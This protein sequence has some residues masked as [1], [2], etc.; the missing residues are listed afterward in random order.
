VDLRKVYGQLVEAE[1]A[2]TESEDFRKT[3]REGY[4]AFV[5]AHGPLNESKG[6]SILESAKDP[7][8]PILAALERQTPAGTYEPA[9]ILSKPTMRTKRRPENPSIRDAFVML[10]NESMDVDLAR[11]AELAGTTE[12][13]VAAELLGAGAIFRTP[14]GNY[15]VRDVYLSG[16]VRRKLREAIEAH[17]NG[18]D[19][20]ANIEELKKVIPPDVPYFAIEAKLG[21]SW[22]STGHYQQFIAE[23]LGVTGNEVNEIEIRPMP[24]GWKVSLPEWM[25]NKPEAR[26]LW[27]VPFY[28]FSNL[29]RAA[30]NN[31]SVTIRYKDENGNLVVDEP[32]SKTAN[33]KAGRIRE[34]FGQWAW[35][36]TARRVQLERDYNEVMNSAADPQFD[37]SFLTFDGMALQRG[38]SEFGLRQHQSDAIWRG[39]A[40][41][42]GIYGH[43]VGTGKTYT[44]GGIAVESRRYGLA[45]KPLLLAHNA[46]SASVAAEIRE[47]YPAA[48][49]LYVDNLS[50][51]TV[52]TTLRQ[53]TNDDWDAVV[54][55]HS[56]IDNF[57][58]S[59]ATL[60]GLVEAEIAAFEEE[61]LAAAAEDGTDLTLAMMDDEDAMKKVRSA[62]AKELVKARN[63]IKKRVRDMALRASKEDAV[64]FEDMGIDMILVDEAHEFKK[65][66]LATRMKLKGLNAGTSNRSI[67]LRFLTDYVRGMNGGRGVH[68]FTGTPI[69]NTLNEIYNQM[70]YVMDDE[71]A[72]DGVQAWDSWFNTFADAATDVELTPTGEYEPVTRLSS[73]VNVAELR[74]MVGQYMHIVFADEMP[75][76]KPRPTSD[77]RTMFDKNLTEAE[78][79]ELLNSRSERPVGRPYKKVVNDTAEMSPVQRAVLERLIGYSRDFKNASKKDRRAIMLSGDPRSPLLVE[80]A[81]A[82]AGFDARLYDMS[83]PDDPNSKVNRAV[84]N[85]LTHY[86]E[87]PAATQVIFME[88][89]FNDYSTRTRT[90][91][92]GAKTTQRVPKFN[93]AKDI[94]SKL[95]AGGIPREQIAIVTGETSKDKR[96]E[97]AD[98]MNRSEIRVVVGSSATLGVGVNMQVNLRAM[99]HL[100]A[101]WMPGLLEQRNGRGHRQ[102]NKWNTVLEYRYL[103][104]GL[105]GRRWQVLAI[106]QKF[107]TAFLKADSSVRIIEGDAVSLDESEGM[108]DLAESLS[109]AAG[110]PRILVRE[111]LKGD[112]RK[113]EMRERMHSQ[114]VEDALD[115]TA[116]QRR[117]AFNS[118]EAARAM[119]EDAA[120]YEKEREKPFAMVIG[121][122]T[123]DKRDAAQE[124]LDELRSTLPT[125]PN[126][127]TAIGNV[128]GFRMRARFTFGGIEVSLDRGTTF[129]QHK[130]GRDETHGQVNIINAGL[131][132]ASIEAQLRGL[133]RRAGLEAE[134]ADEAEQS[135]VKFERAAETP[136]GQAAALTKKRDLLKQLETD[137]AKFPAAAPAWLRNGAPMGTDTFLKDRDKGTVQ[138]HRWGTDNWW[139]LVDDGETVKA[140]PYTDL[141]DEN[142]LPVFDERP[143]E[144]PPMAQTGQPAGQG[145]PASQPS[146]P[147]STPRGIKVGD[148]VE[149]APTSQAIDASGTWT[150]VS[151]VPPTDAGERDRDARWDVVIKE[152]NGHQEVVSASVLRPLA[153]FSRVPTE[154]GSTL[155]IGVRELAHS[156]GMD[157][158]RMVRM[159]LVR[160]VQSPTSLPE[161]IKSSYH[162]ESLGYVRGVWDGKTSYLVADNIAAGDWTGV[163]LHESGTH[164]SLATMIGGEFRALA[165]DFLELVKAGDKTAKAIQNHIVK[166]VRGNEM[167]PDH[168]DE[169]RIAYAVEFAANQKPGTFTGRFKLWLTRVLAALRAWFYRSPLY[170]RLEAKGFRMKLSA[171][172]MAALARQ[173]VR[174]RTA[175]AAVESGLKNSFRVPEV[176]DDQGRMNE[177]GRIP[178]S[179]ERWKSEVS[180]MAYPGGKTRGALV[181]MSPEDFLFLAAD[182]KGDASERAEKYGA[183][184]AEKFNSDWLPY[185]E[186]RK[187]GKVLDHEGRAR[188]EMAMKSGI[189]EIPVILTFDKRNL[190]SSTDDLPGRLEQQKGD[191]KVSTP[192]AIL[193]THDAEYPHK[194]ENRF[195]RSL[196][197]AI[198]DEIAFTFVRDKK[199][200]PLKNLMTQ[201]HKAWKN[202]E[203]KPVFDRGQDFLTDTTKYAMQAESLAPDMLVRLESLKDVFKTGAGQKDTEAIA[204]ALFAGT[205]DGGANPEDGVVWSDADLSANFGLNARQIG[206]YHQARKAIDASL[207]TA[208]IT[209]LVRLGRQDK[210]MLDPDMSLEDVAEV[211]RQGLQDRIDAAKVDL[212]QKE[213]DFAVLKPQRTA[214][215]IQAK[216]DLKADISDVKATI[217]TLKASLDRVNETERRANS[218]KEHGYFPLMRFGEHR[219]TIT[220]TDAKGEQNV[221]FVGHYETQREALRNE[222]NLLED[223]EHQGLNVQAERRVMP[224]LGHELYRGI[225]PETVSLFA[226]QTGLDQDP[227]LQEY[228]K[229]AI[230]G[231][232]AMKRLIHRK[233]MPGF[234]TDIKRAL[235]AFITS[236]AR[237]ASANLHMGPMLAAVEKIKAGDVKDDAIELYRYLTE[238]KEEAAAFRSFLFFW[239]IGASPASALVN[240]T[241]PVM[242]T[243]PYLAQHGVK[244]AAKYLLGATQEAATGTPKA[245]VKRAYDRAM[246]EGVVA[247][248]EIYQLMAT[249]RGAVGSAQVRTRFMKVWGSFF[250]M[251]EA[252]NRRL[253]FLAS[254]RAA[255]DNGL[256]DPYE[257]AKNA[258]Y[259]TQGIYNRGNRPNW[260]RGRI[261]ATVFTFKQFSISY[262]EFLRR[263]PGKERA[264][265]LAFL[266]LA[267]GLEGL[268]FADDLDD[269]I[270]TVGQWSGYATN[271]KKWKRQH[272]EKVLA[273]LADAMGDEDPEATGEVGAEALLHGVSAALPIDISTRFGFGN[274]I[275][276]SAA[277]KP[278]E[279]N[280]VKEATEVFG[281]AGGLVD[282]GAQALEK[283]TKGDLAGAIRTINPKP[284]RDVISGYQ[285]ATSGEFKDRRGRKV[286]GDVSMAEAISKGIGFNPK[287]LASG[288]RKLGEEYDDV[289]IQKNREDAIVTKWVNAYVE[290]D[291]AGQ[292]KAKAELKTWNKEHPDMPIKITQQQ[293]KSRIK[294]IRM[295]KEERFRKATPPEMRR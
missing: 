222:R 216:K 42:R 75:E 2:G 121:D 174:A 233:G 6:L 43:E 125:D 267:A 277:F 156:I 179:K 114:G 85:V 29:L 286:V 39:I 87:H 204:K 187:D 21:A 249:A 139:V 104:E 71:M 10:R 118:R 9:T 124:A 276:G 115:Q 141:R 164:D 248:H 213:A 22:V 295:T 30:M 126:K 98:A 226:E 274:L 211:Y 231:R 132:V 3:L 53:I 153:R 1:R 136:F 134:K 270:D 138:G 161:S 278:S 290:D 20:T 149:W 36:D 162:S 225:N 142:N 95:E 11:V 171:Q 205:L 228:L 32:A 229:T 5:R 123:Y 129:E 143:F 177:D 255:K 266:I 120:H 282:S 68:I 291:E 197:Q 245:D 96:K 183:F 50:R 269:I 119:G 247:P 97:I 215:A 175:G 13:A 257:F 55:P 47:M 113:L 102:G 157:F 202:A 76:F 241:Q 281:P 59:E 24:T 285:A 41:G 160:I 173:A 188:A 106:K 73:F 100:D 169:E 293:L 196:Q 220:S 51:D 17:D 234:N 37:G 74:R 78:K 256:G 243:F 127:V 181:Y 273:Y 94:V 84:R 232:S 230:S 34:E 201:F 208:A 190:L 288:N 116:K 265:A 54:V 262:L 4:E 28:P 252:W 117:Q 214:K 80:T 260:A 172:D 150:V 69:T 180:Y 253:T 31:T 82:N 186:V 224:Q 91:P 259:E 219:V 244:D 203:F 61:A 283:A 206:Y 108:D 56:L 239:F 140:V 238:P 176:R 26:N 86:H 122:K 271:S 209:H 189:A 83:T 250:A 235:A 170:K 112:V 128:A 264:I 217:A 242:M 289:A 12:D 60:N 77:G 166:L 261:G 25:R 23:L 64:S 263:L 221:E 44:M 35:K 45:K 16:N 279:T 200:G 227:L 193:L 210:V 268:P 207:D 178:I 287:R 19:M 258:V 165:D 8:F 33:E 46:N 107:I 101:P 58:L 92:D 88:R 184:D 67:T 79:T 192:D 38:E 99:H 240:A 223:F 199:F 294:A 159:G 182:S 146:A 272:V 144:S 72:R 81:A 49:V 18:Q 254:Y 137:L 133:A 27:G 236:N 90:S 15:D 195:S 151:L 7:H 148:S 163:F 48:K 147:E 105:D 130:W 284:V 198:R 212:Q 191:W 154:E 52:A 185:L 110:D 14:A 135:I 62:T 65:P 167:D 131:K 275:P 158:H 145:I 57:A 70:R 292:D 63:A 280:K 66:P 251:A 237:L 103:T 89:G 194:S 152:E 218:L 93:I 155:K 168:A 111:K 109:S 40:N 246:E